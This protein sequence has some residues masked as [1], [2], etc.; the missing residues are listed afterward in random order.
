[1]QIKSGS[2][3]SESAK[4]A[5][6]S[7]VAHKLRTFLTLLGI[8]IGVASV[9]IVGAGIEGLETYVTDSVSNILGSNSFIIGKYVQMGELSE[10]EW[11]QM[12]KR[13][14]DIKLAH[15]DFVKNN[16][17]DCKVVI[18]ELGTMRSVFYES[19]EIKS[20]SVNGVTAERILLG[21]QEVVEGRFFTE[22]EVNRSRYVCVIGWDLYDQLFQESDALGKVL[23]LGNEPFKVIGVLEKMG[24]SFGQSLDNEI[25]IPITAFQKVYGSRRSVTIRG[26][27]VNQDRFESALDQARAA[28]RVSHRV[29]PGG[30]DTFGI[31]T[32]EEINSFVDDFTGIIAMVVI[33]ITLISLV[34]GG[35][36]V[37]NIMLV[38]VTER[39]FEIG[40]R[41]ALGARR[42]DILNQFLIE[43]FVLAAAGGLIGLLIAF[44]SSIIIE[45]ATPMTMTVSWFYALLAIGVSGGIGIIFGIYPAYSASKLDPI[46]ALREDK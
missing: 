1:M 33:P 29:E 32:T 45:L 3:F 41:K 17:P 30:E 20:T 42:Q 8:I 37:M 5:L 25:H 46:E 34:V 44:I 9:M 40:L 28:M 2:I 35:I 19:N 10:E 22:E 23:R 4:I 13:N 7:I 6:T 21:N 16:C 26:T 36:V 27:A 38:S 39:T 11:E 14:K 43:S 31:I 18:G 12:V 24:S 15:V